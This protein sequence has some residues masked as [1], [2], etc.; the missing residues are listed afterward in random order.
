MIN[1]SVDI[2]VEHI[3][4]IKNILADAMLRVYSQN[5]SVLSLKKQCRNSQ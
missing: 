1:N 4:G 3:A 5:N 2:K